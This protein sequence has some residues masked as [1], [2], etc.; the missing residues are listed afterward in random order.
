MNITPVGAVFNYNFAGAVNAIRENQAAFDVRN[1]SQNQEAQIP[2]G[3][4]GGVTFADMLKQLIDNANVTAAQTRVD[5]S[6]LA[7]G[8]V[9]DGQLH[10][11]MINAEKADLAFRTFV[12]VRNS[13]LE[14]YQ[15]VMR[16]TV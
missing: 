4:L 12:S 15:E 14:A 13:V 11:I 6:N 5:A 16:I 2:Q 8:L 10:N 3:A 1:Q 7:L 9:P